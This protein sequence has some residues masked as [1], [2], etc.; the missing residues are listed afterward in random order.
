MIVYSWNR[1]IS[2]APDI[3]DKFCLRVKPEDFYPDKEE[4]IEKYNQ[5]MSLKRQFNIVFINVWNDDEFGDSRLM[6]LIQRHC[7][8]LVKCSLDVPLLS[9]EVITKLLNQSPDLED[10]TL[11]I[12]SQMEY[13]I[14]S[15]VPITLKKLKKLAVTHPWYVFQFIEAP[16]LEDLVVHGP[17]DESNTKSLE[18]FLKTSTNLERL[19]MDLSIIAKIT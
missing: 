7:A 19:E 10:L 12:R 6:A 18:K 5:L 16:E 17:I 2:K 8:G 11:S 4:S 3:M 15:S 14:H 13:K 9:P 1:V